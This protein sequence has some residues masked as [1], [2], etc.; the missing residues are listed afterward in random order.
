MA[1]LKSV[2]LAKNQNYDFLLYVL[3][4]STLNLIKKLEKY[5]PSRDEQKLN[6]ATDLLNFFWVG[7]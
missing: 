2:Q 6:Y 4:K 5:L 7:Y 3:P 1:F